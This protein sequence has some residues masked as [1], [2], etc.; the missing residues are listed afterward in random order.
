MPATLGRA[1]SRFA[2]K[3]LARLR[4][5]GVVQVLACERLRDGTV[6]LAMELLPGGSLRERMNRVPGIPRDEALELG[7]RIAEVMADVH[8]EGIVHRDLKPENIF[9]C[10]DERDPWGYQLKLLDF[11]IAKVPPEEGPRFDTQLQTQDLERPLGTFRYMA[12]EQLLDPS[13]ADGKVDV[14]A[15]GVL[16]FEL[17]AGRAPFES[18]NTYELVN[19]HRKEQ[20][21]PLWELVPDLPPTLSTFIASMLAKDPRERPGMALC[22]ERLG[23]R[24]D[25]GEKLLPGLAAFT[26]AQS[27]LFLG[28]RAEVDTLLEW[29]ESSRAGRHRWVQVEGLSGVGKSSLLQAGLLPRMKAHPSRGTPR[30]RVVHVRPSGMREALPAQLEEQT[31]PGCLVL[32][33]IDPLEDFFTLDEAERQ[34]LDERLSTALAVPDGRLRLLTTLRV[35]FSDRLEQLP[36][37]SRQ[38]NDARRYS[39]RPMEG[40]ALVRVIEE[41]AWRAGLRLS[42]GLPEQMVRETASEGNPLPLLAHTLQELRALQGSEVLTHE[43]YAQ[44]GGV[45]GSLAR[46]AEELLEELGPPRLECA[47]WMVLSLVQVSKG[48]PTL[49]RTRPRQEVLAAA[50][51]GALAEEVLSRLS[52]MRAAPGGSVDRALRLVIVSGG[53]EPSTQRLE[54]IHDTLLQQMPSIAKWIESERTRLERLTDLEFTAQSWEEARCP[55][56]D[57]P[58]GSLLEHYLE[59]ARAPSPRGPP[60]RTTSERAARFLETARRFD[61]RRSLLRLVLGMALVATTV[62]ALWEKQRAESTL[63]KLI[64]IT[65]TFVMD[66]D[67]QLGRRPYTQE[68]RLELLTHFGALLDALPRRDQEVLDVL[69]TTI[70]TLHRRSDFAFHDETL[71]ATRQFLD[72]GRSA[73]RRGLELHPQSLDLMFEAG[74][75]ASKWG[76]LAMALGQLKEAREF[77]SQA[78]ERF[79]TPPSNYKPVDHRRSLATSHSEFGDLELADGHPTEALQSYDKAI[80]LFEQNAATQDLYDQCLLVETRGSRAEA[81]HAARE[82]KA[83]EDGFQ[84]AEKQ[85]RS[86]SEKDPGDTYYRWVLARLLFKHA[87]FQADR[88]ARP[89]AVALYQ[90]AVRLGRTLHEGEA[91]NKRYGLVLAEGLLGLESLLD[92]PRDAH[93]ERCRLIDYF[94]ARDP[95]D[96]RFRALAC[97]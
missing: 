12:P 7:R 78:L 55:R 36:R 68:P 34:W 69:R 51:G 40:E 26:E 79:Q 16:L 2:D 81:A 23:H 73:I 75:N 8:A 52:G 49:R 86:I 61:R 65:K 93:E 89:R 13:R 66:V 11:G 37:L 53:P 50:G 59:S 24:W 48:L 77:F 96:P 91:P 64:G 56:S 82:W 74:M 54:L 31:P 9:L 63:Q 22:L 57:L 35:E 62:W 32:V 29:L 76:K 72:D 4:H 60:V 94:V 27:G 92:D 43:R 58:T 3:L 67:W 39:L 45:R 90:E 70:A 25:E 17:L 38:L 85:A 20:P 95:E 15:L 33:V 18:T 30:W 87:R 46:R 42:K 80:A 21:P 14:Y 28:R 44:L 97:P 71:S 1:P 47:K 41:M 84:L 88:G 83:A 6:Y 10:P 19:Q 5:A